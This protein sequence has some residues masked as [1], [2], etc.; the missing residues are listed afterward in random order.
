MTHRGGAED[1]E[2]RICN[3]K[4]LRTPCL[5]GELLF[6]EFQSKKLFCIIQHDFLADFGFHIDL[7]ELFQPALDADGGP[8]GAEHR[9]V[10]Q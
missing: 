8:I 10:L 6:L 2:G 5:C 1:A 4:S 3:E 7:L 9:F